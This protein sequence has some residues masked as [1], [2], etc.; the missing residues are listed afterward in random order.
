M[1]WRDSLLSIDWIIVACAMLLVITGLAMFFSTNDAQGTLSPLF[2]RQGL[3]ATAGL[4]CMFFLS[5]VS[6]HSLKRFIPILYVLGV[7]GL[8]VVSVTGRIIRGTISRFEIVG[9]QLQPSEA[10]KVIIVLMLAWFLCRV[11]TPR[12]NVLLMSILIIGIPV[13]LIVAEPDVGMASLLLAVWGGCLIFKG[14]S[15]RVV[16]VLAIIGSLLAV[17][18]WQW[19]LLDYQKARLHSFIDPAGDPLGAGYNVSQS[20]VALGSGQFFGRG[21]GHGPQ[22]QLKFL[23]ERHTDFILASIG[24][25][26]GFVGVGVVIFIYGIMLWRILLVAQ[27]TSEPFG[28]LIAVGTFLTL[29]TSLFVSAGMNMG[30]L[31]VTGIPLSLV[32]YG[33]S[34]LITTFILLT[35]VESVRIHSRFSRHTPP[36][37][38]YIN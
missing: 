32:S 13:G 35:L 21:L 6:Y 1:N 36:E 3:T 33:G 25:E 28:Q 15:W 17:G 19:V 18:A 22:S 27:R 23:P 20:I 34:N 8:V 38:S 37:I 4:L 31:P 7:A 12:L 5:Q 26:L 9:F 14:L 30:L 11:K 29:L 2:I 10:M 16:G 24:E